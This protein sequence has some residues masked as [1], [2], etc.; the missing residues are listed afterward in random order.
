[1]KVPEASLRIFEVVESRKSKFYSRP[2]IGGMSI[3]AGIRHTSH[4]RAMGEI[5][6]MVSI[7]KP[8]EDLQS[9]S[10]NVLGVASERAERPV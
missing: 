10:S 7:F 9:D 4:L 5:G 1:L 3:F 6:R 2:R 8:V